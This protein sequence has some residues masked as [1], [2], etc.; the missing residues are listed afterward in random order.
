MAGSRS[1]RS[2]VRKRELLC[3][4]PADD[5]VVGVEPHLERFAHEHLL[6]DVRVDQ[7]REFG[8]GRRPPHLRLPLVGEAGNVE[9]A[10]LD[11]GVVGVR[12]PRVDDEDRD[13]EQQEEGKWVLEVFH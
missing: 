12:Y 10:D 11:G 8:L 2:S 1:A 9:D 3:Q 4:A 5:D 13:A 7:P 6:A